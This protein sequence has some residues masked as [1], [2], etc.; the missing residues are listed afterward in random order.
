M[1]T[2][3]LLKSKKLKELSLSNAKQVNGGEFGIPVTLPPPAQG[4]HGTH[5]YTSVKTF[6]C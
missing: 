1:K 4:R 5:R 2:S 6:K 3:L